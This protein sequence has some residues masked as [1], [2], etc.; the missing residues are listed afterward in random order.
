VEAQLWN[1]QGA[2]PV[3]PVN[4]YGGSERGVGGRAGAPVY[5]VAGFTVPAKVALAF[6]GNMDRHRA[7]P[8]GSS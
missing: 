1:N 2:R 7:F 8:P 6:A 5:T 4:G 3:L